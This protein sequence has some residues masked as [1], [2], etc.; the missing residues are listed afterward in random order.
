MHTPIRLAVFD[1]AGTTLADDHAVA[2]SFQNAFASNGYSISENEI[3]PL[4]G[5]KK[6]S[7]I[8]LVLERLAVIPEDELV[9]RIHTEFVREMIAYYG[10]SPEVRAL[11]GA[12]DTMRLLR[13]RGMRIA[14]NTGFPKEIADTIL[15]RMLWVKDG[16]VDDY[17]ASDEVEHGRPYPTMIHTLMLRAGID[18]PKAVIK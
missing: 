18:D 9:D 5:Y 11:P 13:Q 2:R 7:A 15:E 3:R 6:T 1:I 12:V 14:L 8:R 17:I 16:I 4:M 10:N